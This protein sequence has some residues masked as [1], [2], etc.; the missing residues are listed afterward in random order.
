MS[1]ILPEF[2]QSERLILRE[3]RPRDAAAIF[4]AYAQDFE[5]AK[6]MTWKPQSSVMETEQFITGCIRAWAEGKRLPYVLALR[7]DESQ[8]I[9]MLDVTCHDHR[10]DIG[11]VLAKAHWGKA[12]MPEAITTF[13]KAALA[14]PTIFRIQASCDAENKASARTLE[15]SGFVREALLERFTVH[16]NLAPEPRAC[17]LYGLFK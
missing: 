2:L 8:P 12:L 15:K 3:P 1:R 6:Y 16:P 11:Y 4:H 17:Y 5:V 14:I 13:A 9:G 7:E 10:L